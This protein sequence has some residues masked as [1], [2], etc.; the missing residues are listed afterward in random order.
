MGMR[1]DAILYAKTPSMDAVIQT[2]VFNFDTIVEED[3][4]SGP[5]WSSILTGLPQ[6]ETRC[7]L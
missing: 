1:P 5:S 3:T 7:K 2:G 4:I 6:S